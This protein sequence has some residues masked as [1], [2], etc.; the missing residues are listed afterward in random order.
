VYEAAVSRLPWLELSW[1]DLMEKIIILP[2]I[3]S[4]SRVEIRTPERNVVFS[5]SGGGDEL[6]V[7]A[8][9][10]DINVK[11]FRTYYQTLIGAAYNEYSDAS[12]ASLPPPFLEITYRYR[13]SGKSADTVSFHRV[14]SR[15]V[16]TSLNRGRPYFTHSA[17]TDQVLTDLDQVLAGQK[18]RSYL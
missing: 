13:D 14:S 17:Y 2:Y 4:V 12:A 18:V 3:D 1:F 15:R 10:I 8:G 5:L 16:L 11:N 7:K 6:Q 9:A